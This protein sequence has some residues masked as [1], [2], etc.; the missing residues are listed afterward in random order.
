MPRRPPAADFEEG[1]VEDLAGVAG[2]AAIE[3]VVESADDDGF[4]EVAD[5]A[6]GLAG[7]FEPCGEGFVVA[8]GIAAEEVEEA[9]SDA[10]SVGEW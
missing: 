10:G 1:L 8:G 9:E 2:G 3:G 6:V 5:G 4:P 7:A